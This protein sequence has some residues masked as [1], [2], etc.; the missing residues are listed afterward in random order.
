MNQTTGDSPDNFIRID[1]IN[2]WTEIRFDLV[3]PISIVY[4]LVSTLILC[5]PNFKEYYRRFKE[6]Q[7]Q[8]E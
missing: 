6:F 8:F 3:I 5:P 2:P 1:P 7:S 4:L